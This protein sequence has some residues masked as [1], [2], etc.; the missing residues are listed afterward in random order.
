MTA[1]E[2]HITQKY[3]A[4]LI[5]IEAVA[6]ILGRKPNALRVLV[7]QGRGDGELAVKLR[8][9]RAQLGRRVMFRT[10]D[11]ARLIDEA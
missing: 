10:A 9:C 4:P 3:G 1:T 6:E 8:A 5:P 2:L 7:N 11:I